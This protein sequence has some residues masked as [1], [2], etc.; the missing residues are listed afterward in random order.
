MVAIGHFRLHSN[1]LPPVTA[2]SYELRSEETGTPFDVETGVAHVKVSS[3]RYVMPTDQ[4]LSSFPPANAV[5]AFGDRLPQIALQR[6][7]LPWERNPANLSAVS[8][9]PWLA[10]VVVAE[11]EAE[12]STPTNVADCSTAS[13]LLEPE[14][15][16]VEQGL[17]LGVT[18]T[19]IDKIFPTIDDLPLL[20]HVR[21]VDVTDT[22]LS[23][24]DD[25]G[26]VAVVMANRLPVMDTANDHPVR[27]LA[28]L[29]SVEGQLDQ[30]PEPSSAV[31]PTFVWEPA[32]DWSHL[33]EAT[34][35]ADVWVSGGA[36]V[37]GVPLEVADPLS[38]AAADSNEAF[39]S[40]AAGAAASIAASGTELDGVRAS[41]AEA[42]SARWT[43][44][45]SSAAK[46]T[47]EVAT[48]ASDPDARYMVRSAMGIG[49]R[50]PITVYAAEPVLRFPVLA[51]WSFTTTDGDTF[52]TLMQGLDVGLVGTRLQ[53]ENA[54]PSPTPPDGVESGHLRLDHRTRRGEATGAWYRGPLVPH[55]LQRGAITGDRVAHASDQ[56]RRV[57]PDG[58]EDLSYAAAFEIGRLLGLSQLSIVAAL[59]RFRRD[60]FGA[61]RLRQRADRTIPFDIG[62]ILEQPAG[63]LNH[64]LSTMF[65]EQLGRDPVKVVGPRRPVADPGRPIDGLGGLS[66]GRLDSLIAEGLGIDEERLKEQA[67]SVGVVAALAETEVPVAPLEASFP[68]LGEAM[69]NAL[70]SQVFRLAETAL[71]TKPGDGVDAEAA[72]ALDQL[73]RRLRNRT[74]PAGEDE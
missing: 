59:L 11:G 48:A 57:V 39:G 25:D 21:E 52:E 64:L 40:A 5:G 45:V 1:V 12:L 15:R 74:I 2:G 49:F 42:A 9:T 36:T 44:T 47:A 8:E 20:A 58:T 33:A 62:N 27:Y 67:K 66:A 68:R 19:V 13:G 24:G 69:Q 54:P 46:V 6:R 17:Y 14:D 51:H 56:L 73:E 7:T 10:L 29:V 50:L 55:P 22:E 38:G 28:C 32:Q 72:D 37:S 3:P 53:D 63:D 70:R 16:D 43:T 30:L 65:M 31:E 41:K 34:T 35:N 61:A 60:Q 26:W 71:P 18:K 23:G 4:I